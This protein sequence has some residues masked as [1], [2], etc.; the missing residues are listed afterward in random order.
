MKSR[1]SEVLKKM[2]LNDTGMATLFKV[3]QISAALEL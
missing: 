3:S 1:L 2:S